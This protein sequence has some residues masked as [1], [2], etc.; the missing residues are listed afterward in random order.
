[1]AGTIQTVILVVAI[2]GLIISLIVVYLMIRRQNKVKWPPIVAE[3]PDW[4]KATTDK[5]G[6]TVCAN[7]QNLGKCA[8]PFYP[9]D[10]M[11]TGADGACN[12]YKW[13]TNCGL[14]WDGIT[15]GVDN[16]CS[17]PSS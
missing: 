14:Q 7:V 2:L 4:W 12:K 16:P 9:D 15:Y 3:C 13:A 8:A 11:Y 10:E 6:K 17:A 1:M 5:N